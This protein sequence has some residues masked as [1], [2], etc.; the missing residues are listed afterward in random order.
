MVELEQSRT[1][2]AL[3]L[4]AKSHRQRL[5]LS[6][7][8]QKQ[9]NFVNFFALMLHD[10]YLQLLYVYLICNADNCRSC[11]CHFRSFNAQF[12]QTRISIKKK[13]EI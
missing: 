10:L 5:A 4:A 13:F 2:T 8:G 6:K 3:P 9:T 11:T 12:F 7:V 1:M